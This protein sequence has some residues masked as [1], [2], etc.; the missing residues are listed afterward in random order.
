MNDI[1]NEVVGTIKF[2]QSSNAIINIP[3]VAKV[4]SY[5]FDGRLA[6]NTT[7]DYNGL[8]IVQSG[9]LLNGGFLK[10]SVQDSNSINLSESIVNYSNTGVMNQVVT[11]FFDRNDNTRI[12][13]KVV[14]DFSKINWTKTLPIL[15]GDLQVFSY[16]ASNQLTSSGIINFVNGKPL[17]GSV[18]EYSLSEVDKVFANITIDFSKLELLG[19]GIIIGGTVG[20]TCKDS[21]NSLL[22]NST[23]EYSKNGLPILAKSLSYSKN[24]RT[25]L[26]NIDFVDV[27]W[28]ALGKIESGNLVISTDDLIDNRKVVHTTVCF[29]NSVPQT[30]ETKYYSELGKLV[31]RATVDF[32]GVT[33]NN[34]NRPINSQ[35]QV[36][37]YDN[38][39][40]LVTQMMINTDS[41]GYAKTKVITNYN[42]DSS[43][44]SV[45]DKNFSNAVFDNRMKVIN[46][47]V[48]SQRKDYQKNR[49]IVSS[50]TYRDN[51][52]YHKMESLIETKSSGV[53]V[54][55]KVTQ[56]ENGTQY[57]ST[58]IYLDDNKNPV[59]GSVVEYDID[60]KTI[61]KKSSIDFSKI[62]VKN[63][64]ITGRI[65]IITKTSDKTLKSISNVLYA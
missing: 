18:T 31:N 14:A 29:D 10:L 6:K 44:R 21:D 51:R 48:L 26:T 63:K 52:I 13:K 56:R 34:D 32:T 4:S 27:S 11:T 30:S 24:E 8:N 15:E 42:K 40:S 62:D 16:N 1:V 54:Y 23:I 43:V 17:S 64:V 36:F 5:S 28:S 58:K 46:G 37:I 22:S 61:V 39:G 65:N 38:L 3:Q 2:L 49:T 20:I 59:S 41:L 33:F 60:G 50:I 47:V 12:H 7:I 35:M 25:Y 57:K 55:S 53:N 45:T 9:D 19:S